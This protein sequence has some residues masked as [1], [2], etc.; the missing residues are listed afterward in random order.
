MRIS[1][2]K[3]DEAGNHFDKGRSVRHETF[4]IAEGC[5]YL[6]EYLEQRIREGEKLTPESPVIATER[7]E[8]AQCEEV[9]LTDMI[10]RHLRTLGIGERPYVL[11]KYGE[12]RLLATPGLKESYQRY[13][14]GWKAGRDLV[15]R[16]GL[17]VKLPPEAVK[18]LRAEYAKAEPFLTTIPQGPVKE[19][20]DLRAEVKRL[21]EQ[22]EVRREPDAIMDRLFEDPGFRD[23]VT[24]KLRELKGT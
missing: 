9:W 2:P 3:F 6:R 21:R 13:F 23:L 19:V 12:N 24:K 16:Y 5:E 10:R 20:E 4:M 22:I 11:K 7:G 15:T 1:V 8:P 17:A 18:E 14:S